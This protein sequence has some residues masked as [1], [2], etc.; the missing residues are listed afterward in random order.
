MILFPVG[1]I[2][3][4]LA[5][6]ARRTDGFH[7]IESVFY[8]LP[9]YDVLEITPLE[10]E[11]FGFEQSG[12]AIDGTPADNLVVKAALAFEEATQKSGAL[13]HLHKALPHGAG[14]GGGSSDAA[15]TLMG[16]NACFGNPLNQHEML[17]LAAQL[18]SDCAFFMLKQAAYLFGTG[19]EIEPFDF[20][21]KGW[22]IAVVHPGFGVSTREAYGGCIP[23][24][25]V[26]DLKA[27]VKQGPE[28]WKG[29]L[30]NDFESSVF[31]KYPAIAEIKSKLYEAGALYASM[32]GSGSA[33]YGLFTEAVNLDHLFP[34]MFCKVGELA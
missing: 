31:K 34:G 6:H 14:L 2:N 22:Y 12:I 27:V 16:L 15:F 4:G 32:S 17:Q 23:Q 3:L 24:K 19:P 20:S 33:V 1:K 7:L 9:F 18:G 29:V 30:I 5:I 8:P 25:P 21:L 28:N 10:E 11:G 26:Y 13:L